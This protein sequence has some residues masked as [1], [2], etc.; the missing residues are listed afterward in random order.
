SSLGVL[1]ATMPN[2]SGIYK[3]NKVYSNLYL[4]V[5]APPA[6]GKGNM[7][8]TK[9][10]IVPIHQKILKDSINEAKAAKKEGR[11]EEVHLQLKIVPTNISSAEMYNAL[12]NVHDSG[13]MIDSEADTLSIM[14]KNDWGNFSDVLRKAFHHESISMSR[15]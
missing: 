13:L 7:M 10:L 6:S 5:I 15:K 11:G 2:V 9:Q 8:Y 14:F 4:L 1:S 12:K 3:N